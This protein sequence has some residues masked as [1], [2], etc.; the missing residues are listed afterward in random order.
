[1]SESSN[2]LH[3]GKIRWKCRRGMAE[4]D[5]ILLDFFNHKYASLN[6]DLQKQF[7][8]LLDE[9]DPTLWDYFLS[10]KPADKRHADMVN[11]ILD[12]KTQE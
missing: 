2:E 8:E 12:T 6:P 7:S 11:L 4:L 9:T 5:I 10:S 3:P 1:V